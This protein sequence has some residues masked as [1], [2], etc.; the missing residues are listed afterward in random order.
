MKGNAESGNSGGLMIDR[1][2]MLLY[3]LDMG[4][5][6]GS[7]RIGAKKGHDSH[8]LPG[9]EG[10]LLRFIIESGHSGFSSVSWDNSADPVDLYWCACVINEDCPGHFT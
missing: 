5:P 9:D 8:T 4:V 10:H 2:T 1:S 7:H 6:H 3:L